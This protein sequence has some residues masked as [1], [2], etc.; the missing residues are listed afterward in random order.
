[1]GFLRLNYSLKNERPNELYKEMKEISDKQILIG[2]SKEEIEEILGEPGYKFDDKSG[3]VYVYNAGK[4][5]TGIFVGN[6]AIIFDYSYVC[7]LRISF[8]ENNKIDY[9]SIHT[10]S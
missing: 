8:D 4:L 1:M 9:T 2:L 5:D 7:D 10:N 3:S 6:T